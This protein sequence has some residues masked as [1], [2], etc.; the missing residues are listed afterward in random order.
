MLDSDPVHSR[1]SSQMF[2]EPVERRQRY[3]DN[4]TSSGGNNK[5]ALTKAP[6][7]IFDG[8][9]DPDEEFDQIWKTGTKLV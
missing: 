5:V 6:R 2:P 8:T 7:L 3:P 9:L 4:I 1:S